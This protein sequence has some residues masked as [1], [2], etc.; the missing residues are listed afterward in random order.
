MDLFN[1]L[2]EQTI[3]QDALSAQ[4]KASQ[5][6]SQLLDLRREH[7]Q[8]KQLTRA[9]WGLLKETQGLSD[10]DLKR[11]LLALQEGAKKSA[12]AGSQWWTCAGCR[13][14]VPLVVK[15]CPYCGRVSEIEDP[16]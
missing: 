11:H 16:L 8:L 3:A 14:Q 2:Y 4:S 5:V 10:A 13:H 12:A 1:F 9:L 7:E 15:T 6:Q